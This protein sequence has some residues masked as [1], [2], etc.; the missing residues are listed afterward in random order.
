MVEEKNSPTY[1]N[2]FSVKEETGLSFPKEKKLVEVGHGH[3]DQAVRQRYCYCSGDCTSVCRSWPSTTRGRSS[4]E[5]RVP[6]S[7]SRDFIPAI[8]CPFHNLEFSWLVMAI[9]SKQ[10]AG[11]LEGNSTRGSSASLRSSRKILRRQNSCSSGWTAWWGQ[12]SHPVMQSLSGCWRK[13]LTVR[14]SPFNLEEAWM[15]IGQRCQGVVCRS[16]KKWGRGFW[17]EEW[18]LNDQRCQGVKCCFNKYSEGHVPS[19]V[20]F[21]R[22]LCSR[23]SDQFT[24]LSLSQSGVFLARH[25]NC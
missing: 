21:R 5:S 24:S 17:W 6:N 19:V 2:K 16:E 23:H 15:S 8:A 4:S 12:H 22:R 3:F 9:V 7:Q 11:D 18:V 25:C 20:R 10:T 13:I 14:C 1:R